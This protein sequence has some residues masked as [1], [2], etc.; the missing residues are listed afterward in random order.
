MALIGINPNHNNIIGSKFIFYELSFDS[1]LNQVA[2]ENSGFTT[3]LF[4]FI[5]TYLKP[6]QYSLSAIPEL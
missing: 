5:L 3:P 6:I 2:D 4:I 1:R